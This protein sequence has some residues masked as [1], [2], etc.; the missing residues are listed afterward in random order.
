MKVNEFLF[1]RNLSYAEVEAGRTINY[2]KS[3]LS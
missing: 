3:S 2:V 1:A